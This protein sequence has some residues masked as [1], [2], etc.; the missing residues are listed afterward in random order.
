MHADH[1][2]QSWQIISTDLIGLLPR[3]TAGHTWPLVMQNRFTKWIELRP[4][5]KANGKATT[6]AIRT[7]IYLQHGCKY[8]IVTDNGCQFT[9]N[10]FREFLSALHIKH[11]QQN[12]Q[13]C[14]QQ[15]CQQPYQRRYP[16]EPQS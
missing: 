13:Q 2:D 9:S 1:V 8:V 12:Q 16:P 15:R 4:L 7:Q 11:Y 3:T 10:E 14:H 6:E 5:K